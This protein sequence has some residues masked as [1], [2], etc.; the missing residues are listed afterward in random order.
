MDARGLKLL[1]GLSSPLLLTS[2]LA[3][4]GL[5][6][7]G[8]ALQLYLAK[9]TVTSPSSKLSASHE[10][11]ILTHNI[12]SL[13]TTSSTN[14]AVRGAL[15][16]V[17]VLAAVAMGARGDKALSSADDAAQPQSTAVAAASFALSSFGIFALSIMATVWL[18][19]GFYG[20]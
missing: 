10:A 17:H 1:A 11:G 19:S 16:M 13:V 4:P 15:G 7:V 2:T 18:S 14:R 8:F 9:I 20:Q 3:Q 12:K 6:A 5:T